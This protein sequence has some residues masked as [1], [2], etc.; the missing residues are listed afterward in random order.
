MFWVP[1]YAGVTAK[2]VLGSLNVLIKIRY[3]GREGS[4]KDDPLS[5]RQRSKEL[6]VNS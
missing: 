4:E 6:Y 1:K 2:T 5:P 3:K